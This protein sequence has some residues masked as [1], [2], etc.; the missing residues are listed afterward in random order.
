MPNTLSGYFLPKL[1]PPCI[2]G[3]P[4]FRPELLGRVGVDLRGRAKVTRID[5]PQTGDEFA[6]VVRQLGHLWNSLNGCFVH[7]KAAVD[8]DLKRVNALVGPAVILRYEAAGVGIVARNGI[9]HLDQAVLEQIDDRGI[10]T[11]A[12]SVTEYEVAPAT[13]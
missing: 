4:L 3:G 1:G 8:F 12:E 10:A 6:E 9:P 2:V 5:C 11:R 7:V 13:S